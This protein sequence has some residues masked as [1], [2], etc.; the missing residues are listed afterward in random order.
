MI[1][2]RWFSLVILMISLVSPSALAADI[3]SISCC[4]GLSSAQTARAQGLMARG[5]V[6]EG[7]DDTIASCLAR[8]DSLSLSRRLGGEVCRR[9][10]AGESD[11]AILKALDLRA[12]SMIPSPAANIDLSDVPMVGE[13]GAPVVLVEYACARCP[14]CAKLTPELVRE[15]RS[16]SLR[17]KV[18]LYFKL[19]PIKGHQ[20]SNEAALAALA[21]HDQGRFW[22]FMLLSYE[23]FSDFSLGALP[24]LASEAGV[25]G[26]DA[27]V[28][29]AAL[30]ERLV[31]SKREGMINGV[32]ATPTFFISGRMWQGELNLE[33]LLDVLGE[34]HER[35]GRAQ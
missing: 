21:A 2:T 7:C 10:K 15:I 28:S 3:G 4:S 11:D 29:S 23:R 8:D 24:G 22:D 27:A 9:V 1:L 14:F 35:V 17:G 6:Y 20:G 25:S 31:A 30:R 26:Y 19:F 16:G 33:M 13:A 34:E 32:K 5:Q 12:R 18:R